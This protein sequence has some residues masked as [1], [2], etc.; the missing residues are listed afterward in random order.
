MDDGPATTG[1]PR[2]PPERVSTFRKG[3]KSSAE[4]LEISGWPVSRRRERIEIE[5]AGGDRNSGRTRRLTT[6]TPWKLGGSIATHSQVIRDRQRNRADG[7]HGN[8]EHC[9]GQRA[10]R[11]R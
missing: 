5:S 8:S 11:P 10:P 2:R 3:D 4:R 1:D 7:H 6:L 9:L